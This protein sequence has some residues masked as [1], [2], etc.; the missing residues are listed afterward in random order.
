MSNPTTQPD[1]LNFNLSTSPP[2]FSEFGDS[3]P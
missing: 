2:S 1:V 3:H